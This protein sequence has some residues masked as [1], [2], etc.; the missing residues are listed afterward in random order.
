MPEGLDVNTLVIGALIFIIAVI[1]FYET[2]KPKMGTIAPQILLNRLQEVNQITTTLQK[3]TC[4]ECGKPMGIE[5]I[6]LFGKNTVVLACTPCGVTLTWNKADGK[7]L[8]PSAWT[9]FGK[10]DKPEPGKNV[11]KEVEKKLGEAG[12]QS[13]GG[14]KPPS[15]K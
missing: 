2:R 13:A 5:T 8:K 15:P 4:Y 10:K 6:D 12:S 9:L 1:L 14:E 3:Q 7:G 11:M